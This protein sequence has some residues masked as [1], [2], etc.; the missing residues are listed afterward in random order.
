MEWLLVVVVLATL[1]AFFAMLRYTFSLIDRAHAELR[2][3]E[4]RNAGTPLTEESGG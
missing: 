3:A 2:E 1:Y 4:S